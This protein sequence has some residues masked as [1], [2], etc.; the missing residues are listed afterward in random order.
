MNVKGCIEEKVGRDLYRVSSGDSH[1]TLFAFE[2]VLNT[3]SK[4]NGGVDVERS[5]TL[6]MKAV[7][8][9]ICVY[10]DTQ[11]GFFSARRQYKQE[12]DLIDIE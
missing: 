11:C 3:C 2:M 12:L 4:V 7:L 6:D 10:A 5:N 1:V 8:D 9:R